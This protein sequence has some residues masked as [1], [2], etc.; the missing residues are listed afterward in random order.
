[1]IQK[2]WILWAVIA[3]ALFPLL[4]IVRTLGDVV[5]YSDLGSILR[6]L[7]FAL[8]YVSAFV[9]TA[10]SHIVLLRRHTSQRP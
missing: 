7:G 10:V 6:R 4:E 9:A 1:M 3:L 2:E 8:F 5:A